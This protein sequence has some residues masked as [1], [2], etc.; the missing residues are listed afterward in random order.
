MPVERVDGSGPDPDD[1]AVV[2]QRG[3]LDIGEGQH[4]R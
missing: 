1:H 3:M 2:A 4:V